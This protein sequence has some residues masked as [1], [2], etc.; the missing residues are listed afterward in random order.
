MR[1]DCQRNP[2][3]KIDRQNGVLS[4]GSLSTQQ[5]LQ[6]P[7]STLP[8]KGPR[9]DMRPRGVDLVMEHFAQAAQQQPSRSQPSAANSTTQRA[10]PSERREAS[11][12]SDAQQALTVI[13]VSTLSGLLTA[14]GSNRVVRLAKGRYDL[15]RS[16]QLAKPTSGTSVGSCVQWTG[17][18]PYRELTLSGV[19]NLSLIGAPG[20]MIVAGAAQEHVLTFQ[21]CSNIELRQVALSR[22]PSRTRRGAVLRLVRCANI[23]AAGLDMAGIGTSGLSIQDCTNVRFASSA[24]QHCARHQLLIRG[25]RNLL[26]EECEFRDGVPRGSIVITGSSQVT[27]TRAMISGNRALGD[28]LF[29][30]APDCHGIAL[31]NSTIVKNQASAFLSRGDAMRLTGNEYHANVFNER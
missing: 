1:A 21:D 2:N 12:Q 14:L 15:T 31:E 18:A 17:T 9:H 13:D 23:D 3:D 20:V 24:I 5:T 27:F 29:S 28:A 4:T 11:T 22:A 10:K 7:R 30:I 6:L 25:S 19:M 26:F 8:G 16:A